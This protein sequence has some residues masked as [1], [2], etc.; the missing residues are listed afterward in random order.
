MIA[1]QQTNT[2]N[3]FKQWLDQSTMK[4]PDGTSSAIWDQK[5]NDLL[6]LAQDTEMNFK[7]FVRSE[8]SEFGKMAAAPKKE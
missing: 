2:D 6:K 7:E 3:M 4:M 5:S 1:A 8:L